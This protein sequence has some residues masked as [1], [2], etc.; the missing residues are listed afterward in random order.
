VSESF[1][2]PH[3]ESQIEIFLT[4]VNSCTLQYLNKGLIQI[5][6][7]T[8]CSIKEEDTYELLHFPAW[9]FNVEQLLIVFKTLC[10]KSSDAYSFFLNWLH[11]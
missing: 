3:L 7:V 1:E 9:T 4:L 5:V 2:L 6:H 8:Y 11:F 10:L